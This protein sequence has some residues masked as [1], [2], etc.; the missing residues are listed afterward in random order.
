MRIDGKKSISLT[1]LKEGEY[2]ILDIPS[3][4]QRVYMKS[5]FTTIPDWCKEVKINGCKT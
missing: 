2:R 1:M 4:K 3:E 5:D